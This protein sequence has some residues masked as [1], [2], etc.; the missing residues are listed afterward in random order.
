MFECISVP[1]PF[2]VGRVNTYL[3]GRTVVDP[4][5]DSETAWETVADGLEEAGLAPADVEQVVIT[6]PHPDHFGLAGRFRERGAAVCASP[7]AAG[8]IGDFRGR[9]GEE[10][11]FFGPFL[12]RCGI[13]PETAQTAITLPDAFL[14]FAPDVETDVEL[15][16]GDPLS[17]GDTTLHAE[18]VEG[19]AAGERIFPFEAEGER[20][21]IVGDHV[22]GSITPNPVMQPPPEPGADRPRVLPA[23]NRSLDRLREESY[24][25]FLP[26]HGSRIDDPAGR[27]REIRAAHEERTG[28]VRALIDEPTTPAEVMRGLFGDLPATEIFSGMSEAVGHLDVLEARGEAAREERDGELGYRLVD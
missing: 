24:D 28:E 23:Y 26:G 18:A 20:R 2:E 15:A 4:G 12:E 10:Q 11:A 1:T 13:T 8:V 3:T 14:K 27:I 21:A 5:P 25:Q 17:V 7:A 22:L 6:H 16:D 19:H 9:L